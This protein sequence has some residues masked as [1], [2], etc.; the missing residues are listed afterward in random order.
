MQGTGLTT[1]TGWLM[2][3]L[4]WCINNFVHDWRDQRGKLSHALMKIWI[5]FGNHGWKWSSEPEERNHPVCCLWWYRPSVHM[6]YGICTWL[7]AQLLLSDVHRT[8]VL[9]HALEQHLLSRT[10]FFR[11][12]SEARRCQ[13]TFCTYYKQNDIV[14]KSPGARL[15]CLQLGLLT[16]WKH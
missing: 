11:R 12:H 9:N 15:T 3:A 10:Y 13:T 4:Q 2:T 6:E 16:T 7:K 14:L 8:T 1:N 5:V